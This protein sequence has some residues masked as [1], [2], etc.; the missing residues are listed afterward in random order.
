[1]PT[2]SS[3]PPAGH[4]APQRAGVVGGVVG[5][6]AAR[7]DLPLGVV[8][9]VVDEV[10]AH[11]HLAGARVDVRHHGGRDVVGRAEDD[12]V[13]RPRGLSGHRHGRQL[14]ALH[15]RGSRGRRRR[16]PRAPP[17]RRRASPGRA[18]WR[19]GRATSSRSARLRRGPPTESMPS[20]PA[21]RSPKRCRKTTT[22]PVPSGRA[23]TCSRASA[24]RAVRPSWSRCSATYSSAAATGS[25]PSPEA[26][27]ASPASIV[28]GVPSRLN[29]TSSAASPCGGAERGLGRGLRAA[30]VLV[31]RRAGL[32]PGTRGRRRRAAC[33]GCRSF[34]GGGGGRRERHGGGDGDDPAHEGRCAHGG[35]SPHRATGE[36]P[37]LGPR[38]PPAG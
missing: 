28:A 16:L 30:G 35:A 21:S 9:V 33:R 22:A 32:R 36:P 4:P 37:V 8:G 6:R 29:R 17:P 24:P 7:E 20:Y 27:G 5:R 15:L 26:R 14:G 10:L 13:R 23:A 19:R 2:A 31:E 34:G 11:E 12:L 38:R 3:Q 18:S 25:R 1:M